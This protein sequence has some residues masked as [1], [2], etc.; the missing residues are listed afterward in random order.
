MT[1]RPNA[2]VKRDPRTMRHVAQDRPAHPDP[3]PTPRGIL[4]PYCGTVSASDPRRCERCGGFFDP[5]SRQATQNAMGPWFIRE[6]AAPF[7]PGCSFETI[8]DLVRRGK[9][10]RETIL[11]GPSTR[12]YW[13]FASRT[14]GIANLLG[15]CHNCRV[16]VKPDDF[17]CAACG[18]VFTPETDRQHMGLAPVH[19][20]PGQASPE[21]IAA[22]SLDQARQR[23]VHPAPRREPAK[24]AAA[25]APAPMAR[26]S[27]TLRIVGFLV[28]AL[29]LL[30]A[31]AAG[32]VRFVLPL[33]KTEPIQSPVPA[34]VQ[35]APKPAAPVDPEPP[36]VKS[37]PP[38]PA[39]SGTS[40]ALVAP[41]ADRPGPSAAIVA[42]LLSDRFDAATVL[43][44]LEELKRAGQGPQAKTWAVVVRA[45]AEQQRLRALP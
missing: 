34:P 10:T 36:A 1:A 13:N 44:D 14:P 21:I 38:A 17:S 41:P 31:V 8:R 23:P 7:R 27:G 43:R 25:P 18:A 37:E 2:P 16:P 26:S 45:R 9:V 30:G 19:L 33:L 22:A 15:A 35:A 3:Q 39:P 42:A 6:P 20:L 32:V 24:R 12:Q 4:C 5:L 28:V 29:L 11:R 40:P